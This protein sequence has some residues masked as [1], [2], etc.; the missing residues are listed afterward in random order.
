MQKNARIH[1]LVIS[2]LLL[3]M[4]AACGGSKATATPEPPA[5][6]ATSA[7]A[8]APTAASPATPAAATQAPTQTLATA[9]SQTSVITVAI[10]AEFKPFVFKD[11]TGN[12]VGFDM[13][14]MNALSAAGNFEVA[15]ATR[16]FEGMIDDVAAGKYDAAISA[17]TI[18]DARKQQVDFTAPYFQPGQA[19]VSYFS[20]GQG[21]GVR[22]DDATITS[23]ASLTATAGISVGVKRDTTG[24]AFVSA[25][26]GVNV[27]RFDESTQA[28][29][30]LVAGKVEAVVVDIAVLTDYIKQSQGKVKLAG[31]LVTEEEYG[32]AVNKQ[33][34]QVR[35]MLDA[36]LTKI[37]ADGTYDKI[38][39]KWFGAP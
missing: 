19:P 16:P 36:A 37:R 24:D 21:L 28:L 31:G 11:E 7:A 26:P 13:D 3:L 38:F 32:I 12:I 25:L 34:P 5:P 10:N 1:L 4:L 6:T 18:T 35:E 22:T 27:V 8:V 39:A 17:I 2:A 33:K 15:Y 30:A 20:S 29:D 14:L 9:P 23:A